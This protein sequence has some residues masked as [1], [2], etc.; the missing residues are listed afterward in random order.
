ML[1]KINEY[2]KNTPKSKIQED[3]E[4]SKEADEIGI[5][6]TNIIKTHNRLFDLE[7]DKKKDLFDLSGASFQKVK[8]ILYDL[9]DKIPYS[10][11]DV[12]IFFDYSIKLTVNFNNKELNLTTHF[13]E[14]TND[15]SLIT[16]YDLSNHEIIFTNYN[17]DLQVLV[18]KF[19]KL[20]NLHT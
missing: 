17:N 6:V 16:V 11:L 4:K 14:N 19:L 13:Q 10:D 9:L 20:F 15:Y 8:E 12:Y 5:P 3:W 1:K 7:I 18:E 2:F